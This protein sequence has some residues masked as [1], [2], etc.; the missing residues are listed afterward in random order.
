[1]ATDTYAPT[2][3]EARAQLRRWTRGRKG[4]QTVEPI[5]EPMPR[6]WVVAAVEAVL[7]ELD[8]LERYEEANEGMVVTCLE[9]T[10][11]EDHG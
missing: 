10:G 6:G 5:D 2:P 3:A 8:Q 1:M 7:D 9:A 4:L 11:E